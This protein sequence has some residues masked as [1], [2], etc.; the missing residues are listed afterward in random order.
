MHEERQR[1][2]K[3]HRGTPSSILLASPIFQFPLP[4]S[5]TFILTRFNC[6]PVYHYGSM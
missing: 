4:Y 1:R 2:H 6:D 3:Q 5:F